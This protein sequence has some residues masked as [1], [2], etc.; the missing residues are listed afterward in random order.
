LRAGG[1]VDRGGA[2]SFHQVTAMS[3]PTHI[4]ASTVRRRRPVWPYAVG[5]LALIALIVALLL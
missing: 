4:Y 5:T 1:A 2:P 3:Q